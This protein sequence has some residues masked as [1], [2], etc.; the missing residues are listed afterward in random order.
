MQQL[1]NVNLS[2]LLFIDA[3]TVRNEEELKEG[4]AEFEAWNYKYGRTV[5]KE[6]GDI[7]EYYLER[8]SLYAEF[9]KLVCISVGRIKKGVLYITTYKDKDEKNLLEAFMEDLNEFVKARPN[10]R[11][12]G[13]GIKGFDIPFIFR[14][15]LVNY[16]TPNRLIDV[17][18]LKPWEVTA[19][20]TKDLWKGSGYYNSSLLA[21]CHALGLKSPKEDISGAQVGDVYYNEGEAG[22]QR[23]ADYCEQDVLAVANVVKRCRFEEIF[24]T[25]EQTEPKE[26]EELG[27][28]D[29]I[30]KAGEITAQD[31]KEILEK[32]KG[33]GIAE[34]EQLIAV[35][36]SALL[37]SKK[38]LKQA[39][40]LE[41]LTA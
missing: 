25:Y 33:A 27:L 30:A 36:K 17:G 28:I 18:G 16:V 4:T 32:V 2:D 9:S 11:L 39:L 5:E 12:V 41:I 37:M 10:T 21:V 31:E 22:L 6:G 35:L 1:K 15:S 34:K 7:K 24:N 19:L 8:S 40:E 13:H 29:R 26:R 23:I 20:D 38:E 14:R 3:E